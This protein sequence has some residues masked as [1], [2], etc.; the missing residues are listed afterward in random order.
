ME[1]GLEK[2]NSA[3][4]P[5]ILKAFHAMWDIFPSPVLLLRKDRTILD[6]NQTAT[7]LGVRPG[8]KCFQLSGDTG[9]HNLCLGNEALEQGVAKRSVVYSPARKQVLDSYWLPLGQGDLFVHFGIDI[10]EYA[11]PELFPET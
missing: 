5:D 10:T 4:D 2:I 11:K 6:C 7:A 3:I 9:I 8:M 1:K